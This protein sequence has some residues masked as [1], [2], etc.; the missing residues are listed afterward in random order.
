MLQN[1]IDYCKQ[2]VYSVEQ[3]R[4]T[5]VIFFKLYLLYMLVAIFIS[6]PLGVLINLTG[7]TSKLGGVSTKMIFLGILVLPFF[8]ETIF[9]LLLKPTRWNIRVFFISVSIY[10]SLLIYRQNYLPVVVFGGIL[11]FVLM[12]IFLQKNGFFNFSHHFR[13]LFYLSAAVF[14]ILHMFNFSQINNN[15]YFLILPVFVIPQF[16]MG[17]V[18]GYTRMVYGFIYAVLLHMSINTFM[19]LKLL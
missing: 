3:R 4:M 5:F 16:F 12:L 18:F 19:L 17:L 10:I 1:F 2:P 14:A 8:E 7:I 11:V 15:W 13:Y 6:A 9:R